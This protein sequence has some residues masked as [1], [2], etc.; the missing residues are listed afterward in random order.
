MAHFAE[1]DNNNIVLRV[2]VVNDKDTQD[3]S[4]VEVEAIGK[5]FL[6]NTLGGNWVQ[7]SINN[8]IRKRF[9]CVGHIYDSI[10]DVFIPPQP[11]P[12]WTL[13]T[14]TH[15]WDPPIQKPEDHKHI[16]T[17]EWREE[18]QI[19]EETTPVSPVKFILLEDV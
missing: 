15:A 4:G 12:S 7:T 3:E 2:I 9:A 14:V 11:F 5:E 16:R 6:T 18:Q 10:K 19:W 8:K 13:N 1:L 17:W